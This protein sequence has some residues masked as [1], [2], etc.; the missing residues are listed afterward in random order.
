MTVFPAMG[1][2]I[3]MLCGMDRGKFQGDMAAHT[4]NVLWDTGGPLGF[5]MIERFV[6][7]HGSEKFTYSGE[8]AYA[9]APMRGGGGKPRLLQQ[10]LNADISD[11]DKANIL[12]GNVAR[13]FGKA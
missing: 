5:H 2:G 1:A 12:G 10:I 6:Q 7:E 11:E 13:L 4:P 8:A 3:T 9:S